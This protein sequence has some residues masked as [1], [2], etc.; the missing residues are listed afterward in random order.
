MEISVLVINLCRSIKRMAEINRRLSTVELPYTRISAVDGSTL[1]QGQIDR[2]YSPTLNSKIY[3]RPLSPG[4]IGCYMSHKK[5]W[6]HIVDHNLDMCLILEDDAEL[7]ARLPDL[8]PLI[9]RYNQPWDIIKLCDPPKQKKIV[10]SLSLNSDFKLCQ[11]EKIPSRATG[12]L[13]SYGGAVKLLKARDHFGRPLDDDLQF[14][15]EYQG[16]VM[17]IEPSPIWNSESSLKSDIDAEDNRK[18]TKTR[19]ASLKGPVLRLSYELNLLR[20]N[21]N[22]KGLAEKR[23]KVCQDVE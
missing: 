11:Y 15:W 5:C 2:H 3:R 18:N 8:F 13:M 12:Y 22:R 23:K 19:T 4:E 9:E 20:H 7:D 10:D 1:S 6:Q 16:D 14:Y 17:G 21:L